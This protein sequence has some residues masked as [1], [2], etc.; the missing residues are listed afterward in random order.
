[1][2]GPILRL[3][4]RSLFGRARAWLMI[5][6]PVI[7]LALAAVMR[8]TAGSGGL[9]P[10]SAENFLRIFGIGIAVPV[11]ALIAT[12]TLINS[13]F[14]D[15]SIIY[16]LT[17]PVS[18]VT[19]IASKAVIVLGAGVLFG[20]AMMLV[21]GFIMV[22]G[23]D[24][25]AVGALIGGVVSTVAYVGIFTALATTMKRSV[26]GC[27]LFWLL[28][29]STVSALFSPV[30]W[31]SARAWGNAVVQHI[32]DAAGDGK[33]GVPLPYAVLAAIVALAAGV[34]LAGQRLASMT[35]S[36]E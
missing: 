15:G 9:D 20:A 34:A 3:G 35:I 24:Q 11:V 22:G 14:D 18:R 5:A 27:L 2:N 32:A 28:W 6:M 8:L 4:L 21:A 23:S 31:L 33:P 16:L 12:T 13:E 7:M 26:V 17:K 36:E 19:I 29:E 1:M 25:V 10:N 30:K